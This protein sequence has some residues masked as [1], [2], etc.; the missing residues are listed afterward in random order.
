M[1]GFG[2]DW[3]GA[4]QFWLPGRKAG[5]EATLELPLQLA[6]TYNPAAYYTTAIDYGIVQVLI[7]GKEIG[8]PTDCCTNGVKA[9]GKTSLGA[10]E[11]TAGNHR[12]TFRAEE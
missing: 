11:L 9:K 8:S 3:S 5:A 10:V 12:I 1:A 2:H 7:D 6:G 4:S